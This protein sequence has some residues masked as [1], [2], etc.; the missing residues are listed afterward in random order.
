[1]L[2]QMSTTTS[3]AQHAFRQRSALGLAAAC[4][5]TGLLMLLSVARSWADEPQPLFVAWV[6]L[7]LA[8]VW[9]LFVRPAVLLDAEGVTVRN[10]LRDIHIPWA[11]VTDVEFRWNLR[12]FVGDRAYTAWAITTQIERPKSGTGG[13]FGMLTGRL[14]RLAAADAPSTPSKKVTASAV[15]RLIEQARAE[16]D[17]AVAQGELAP[18]P[19]LRVRI[20]WEPLVLA[21][22]LLP[23]IAVVALSLT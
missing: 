2:N 18:A 21:A 6:L 13:M 20:R 7:V 9:A 14:D 1:M 8:V 11:L 4:G 5:V 17:D 15:A 3:P 10:V 16:Y 19:D 22:L 23:A 12:V